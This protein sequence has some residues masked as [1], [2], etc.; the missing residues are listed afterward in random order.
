MNGSN[1]IVLRIK[2]DLTISLEYGL[3]IFKEKFVFDPLFDLPGDIVMYTWREDS[4][5]YVRTDGC[6]DAASVS[7][8]FYRQ[9]KKDPFFKNYILHY[10]GRARP[11]IFPPEVKRIEEVEQVFDILREDDEWN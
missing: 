6:R 2:Q 3:L 1:A 11:Y 4:K 5:T 9:T 7:L 8:K 10:N